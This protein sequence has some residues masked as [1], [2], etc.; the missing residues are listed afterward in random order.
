MVYSAIFVDI[1]GSNHSNFG[2]YGLQSGDGAAAITN[3]EQIRETVREI[4]NNQF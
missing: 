1:E 2:D 4:V 3:E